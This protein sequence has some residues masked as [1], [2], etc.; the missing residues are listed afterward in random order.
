MSTHPIRALFDADDRFGDLL[1]SV[2][3]DAACE[4][5]YRPR[6]WTEEVRAAWAEVQRLREPAM[7]VLRGEAKATAAQ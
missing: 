5:R 7:A 4:I 6:A 2:Y 1:R 3:G